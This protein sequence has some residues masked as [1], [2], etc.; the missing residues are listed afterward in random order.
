MKIGIFI[1]DCQGLLNEHMD[2]P[3]ASEKMADQGHHV[4]VVEDFYNIDDFEKILEKIDENRFE[5]IV[6]AGDSPYS[7]KHTRNGQYLITAICEKGINANHIEPVNLRNMVALAHDASSEDLVEKACL[8]ME[9]AVAKIACSPPLDVVEVTPR[10]AAAVVG[11][12]VGSLVAAQDLLDQGYKVYAV[13]DS[14]GYDIP[15]GHRASFAP[16]EVFVKRNPRYLCHPKSAPTRLVG[17]PGDYTL[18]VSNG[19]KQSEIPVGAVV[20]TFET[21]APPVKESQ[22]IFRLDIKED[23]SVASLDDMSARSQTLEQGIFIVNPGKDGEGD[24]KTVVLAADAAAARATSLLSKTEIQ[25][26][27][28]IS[29]V[30]ANLCGGCGVCLKACVFDAVTIRQS[31]GRSEIDP[32]KCRGCGN[33]VTACPTGARDLVARPYASLYSAVDIYSRFQPSDGSPKVLTVACEGCGYPCLDRAGQKNIKYPVGVMPLAVACG[34]QV[35]MQ[36]PL[37][38][39]ASGFDAVVLMICGEG[40]CHN[41]IGNVDLERRVNLLRALLDSREIDP[42]RVH[43]IATCARDGEACV[44]ELNDYCKRIAESVRR[45][46]ANTAGESP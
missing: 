25:N 43:V 23:G 40:C 18:A 5:G 17:Y 20:V 21:G 30:K 41:V 6:L 44:D 32:R 26:Q 34:G 3:A 39:F 2:L 33:C 27:V 28:A 1:S 36:L 13:F 14:P 38:G 16:T 29:R 31:L 45:N 22:S 42:S 46:G 10:K 35:D 15:A 9:A 37:H 24:L 12:G 4:E 19:K 11:A 7:Y 8:M